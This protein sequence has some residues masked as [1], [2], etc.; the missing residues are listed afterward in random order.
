MSLVAH[1]FTKLVETIGAIL[2]KKA[3]GGG[4][5]HAFDDSTKP[6]LW[7]AQRQTDHVVSLIR[8]N[9]FPESLLMTAVKRKE[10]NLAMMKILVEMFRVDPNEASLEVCEGENGD[11]SPSQIARHETP[12]H[13]LARGYCWW[14]VYQGLPYLL[15]LPGINVNPRIDSTGLTP[16]HLAISNDFL[17]VGGEPGLYK[18]EAVRFLLENGAD[19]NAV[20]TNSW[21]TYSCLALAKHCAE[22]TRLL[23]SHG[24]VITPESFMAVVRSLEV[25]TLEALLSTG[26]NPNTV[27]TPAV[28][29]PGKDKAMSEAQDQEVALRVSAGD[30]PRFR[31]QKKELDKPSQRRAMIRWL[32]EHGADPFLR[33]EVDIEPGRIEKY[34]SQ[35]E[36]RPGSPV[37]NNFREATALHEII[38]RSGLQFLPV[39]L[40]R[41]VDLN[42]KDSRG[43]SVFHAACHH[44][45][46]INNPWS[47]LVEAEEESEASNKASHHVKQPDTPTPDDYQGD[48]GETVFE[49]LLAVGADITTR[50]NL[51]RNILMA[52]LDRP[53]HV[54][55]TEQCTRAIRTIAK[56]APELINQADMNGETPLMYAVRGGKHAKA[57]SVLS[58]ASQLVEVGASIHCKNKS[59][60]GLLHLL[61][62]FIP[63]DVQAF[64]RDLVARG[65]DINGRNDI[66]ETPLFNFARRSSKDDT[67]HRWNQK[68]GGMEAGA[69]EMFREL[70]ADF[71]AKDI[72]GRGLLHVAAVMNCER[73]KE[74]LAEGLDPLEE[75]K[76]GQTAID[77]AAASNNIGVL[78]LFQKDKAGKK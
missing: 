42:V 51:D 67:S 68:S 71:T 9:M 31:S 18:L 6:G 15:R 8:Q 47:K 66:G 26:F 36:A 43:F 53:T 52:M 59:G 41:G 76:D 30:L 33:F 4:K 10:P 23:L 7:Y 54:T 46:A 3:L 39:F 48:G 44:E 13:F 37:S 20:V 45:E 16:L 49:H 50:D 74:L 69:I 24:A 22:M 70:G 57:G 27:F 14:H 32:L 77:K 78:K 5:W 72:Q 29:S 55:E 56:E 38:F 34:P 17:I 75:D 61:T 19:P 2:A 21:G 28:K 58:H 62:I 63:A 73:F 12:L 1:G 25:Q 65:L 11:E 60:D 64:F 40:E 35:A